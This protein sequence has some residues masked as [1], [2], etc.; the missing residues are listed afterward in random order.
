MK[1]LDLVGRPCP[2]RAN[3]FIQEENCSFEARR[4]MRL[5]GCTC[6]CAIFSKF[7]IT[8]APKIHLAKEV[9]RSQLVSH[10][11]EAKLLSVADQPLRD[12]IMIS[13]VEM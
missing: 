11:T 7:S 4:I 5:V 3:R 1:L 10:E 13:S 6:Q 9:G 12:V 2:K 8:R